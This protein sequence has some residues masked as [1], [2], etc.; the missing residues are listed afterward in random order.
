MPSQSKKAVATDSEAPEPMANHNNHHLEYKD[1]PSKSSESLK[2]QIGLLLWQ[3]QSPL[4]RRQ[5]RVCWQLF[6]VLLMQYLTI[7][8]EMQ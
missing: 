2:D 4:G 5:R 7:R 8:G 3:L 6:K 1:S